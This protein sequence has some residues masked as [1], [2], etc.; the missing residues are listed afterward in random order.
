MS[1]LLLWYVASFLVV[2]CSSQIVF[3]MASLG[4]PLELHK[5]SWGSS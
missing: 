3:G 1:P 5:G 2:E 4:N